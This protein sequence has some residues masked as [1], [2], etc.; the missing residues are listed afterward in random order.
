MQPIISR[1]SVSLPLIFSLFLILLTA[2][3]SPNP[4]PTTGL[5]P[6]SPDKQVLREPQEGGDFDS[7][8]P[9]LTSMNGEPYNLLYEGLVTLRDDG[10]VVKQLASAYQVSP[11]GLTNTFTLKTGLTFN[12]GTPLTANDVAYS[13]NRVLLPATKSFT[14]STLSL[15]KDYARVTTG[16]IPTLIGDS[17]IVKDPQT[18]VLVISKPAAYFLSTLTS[19]A[20]DVVEQVLVEKYGTSWTAHLAEGGGSGPFKVQSYGHTTALVLVPNPH[21]TAFTPKI[22]KIIYTVASDRSSNYKAFQGGQY[23]VAFVPTDMLAVAEKQAGFVAVPGLVTTFI[24]MN[25]LVKPLNNIHIRPALGLAIN[26]DLIVSRVVGRAP[27]ATPSNHIVPRG[28]PGYNPALTGPAGVNSTAGDTEKA[29]Q[30]FKL[31]LQEEGYSSASQFPPLS[32]EYRNNRGPQLDLAILDEWKAV[33]GITIKPVSAPPAQITRDALATI[34]HAGPLQLWEWFW[35]ATY[36]D[37]QNGLSNY[38][39]KGGRSNYANYGQNSSAEAADQQA[40]Q[41]ELAQADADQ[42]PVERAR[43]YQ[44]AEQKIVNGAGW[45]SLYQSSYIYSVNPKLHGWKPSPMR[46]MAASDWANIYFVQ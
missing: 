4:A 8:D 24:G 10:T 15:L 35:P 17:I 6:A 14:K 18:V 37:P 21:Y 36:P 16:Q 42:N 13:L 29:R 3:G 34:G 22:Q 46:F 44:D 40:V 31:G 45:I 41:A 38:F 1:K 11:D 27:I 20:G 33:L 23:D 2:C 43:L 25:Y 5:T 9:A 19:T 39:G 12:D 32:F 30:L 7:L 26:R 28:M